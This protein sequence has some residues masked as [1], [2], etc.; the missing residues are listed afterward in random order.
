MYFLL[1]THCSV[2]LIHKRAEPSTHPQNVS[3]AVHDPTPGEGVLALC[4]LHAS[5]M[6]QVYLKEMLESSVYSNIVILVVAAVVA[7]KEVSPG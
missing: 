1:Q 6:L 4:T 5:D 3:A 2:S 7:D